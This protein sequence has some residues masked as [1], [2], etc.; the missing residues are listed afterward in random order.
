MQKTKED[1]TKC[2]QTPERGPL[3]AHCGTLSEA[4]D[5]AQIT[6]PIMVPDHR[7]PTET[8]MIVGG[9][10]SCSDRPSVMAAIVAQID[11]HPLTRSAA[12]ND[13][14]VH[15]HFTEAG[16]E[17]IRSQVDS[18]NQARRDSTGPFLPRAS[19]APGIFH[20]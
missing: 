18:Y 13:Q 15:G 11:K 6:L 19:S 12:S 17:R 1:R 9:P 20:E 4:D 7:S 16:N 10:L 8:A 5:G 2:I 14:S 3:E